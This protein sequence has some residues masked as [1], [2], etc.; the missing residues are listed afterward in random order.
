MVLVE[1]KEYIGI[2]CFLRPNVIFISNHAFLICFKYKCHIINFLLTSIAWYV[3]RYF[4]P[5]SLYTN[6]ARRARSVKK[7]DLGS[8]FSLYRRL[9]QTSISVINKS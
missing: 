8:I 1:K 7:K 5:R 9:V 3:Q 4:G 6:L 2:C